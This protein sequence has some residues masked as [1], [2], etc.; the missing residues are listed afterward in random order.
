LRAA[1]K[2]AVCVKATARPL[3]WSCSHVV[4]DVEIAGPLTSRGRRRD[5]LLFWLA[6]ATTFD[7]LNTVDSRSGKFK[8]A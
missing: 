4:R 8:T 5:C 1:P 2:R 3:I 6:V 7:G